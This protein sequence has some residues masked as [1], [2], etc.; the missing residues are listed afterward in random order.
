L[1][2]LLKGMK[3]DDAPDLLVGFD[4]ADD[5]GVFRLRDDLA[6]VQTVDVITPVCDDPFLFGQVAAANSLS[7]VYAMGG[8][9][10]TVMN[11]C[12]FPSKGV[13]PGIFERIL[14]GGHQKTVEAGAVLVGGHTVKDEEL[15]FGLSVTGTIH[16]DKILRNST[17]KAG[18][19]LVLTKPLGTGVM[20]SASNRG[21][22]PWERFERVVAN[23]ARLNAV[24]GELAAAY[25]AGAC[26]DVTGFGLAGHGLEM[27]R[28]A[29]VGLRLR[30]GRL[31]RY[32]EC[33]DLIAQGVRVGM[34]GSN[35]AMAGDAVEFDGGI[36]ESEQ[37]MLFDP[38]TSGGLLIAVEAA[39]AA[40][41]VREMNELGEADAVVVGE[42]FASP[43]PV[44]HVLP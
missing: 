28:G 40:D 20:I 11:I 4:T 26:T 25:E 37:W 2:G 44:I 24:A 17:A 39:K 42:V 14:E 16:P 41:L 35:R 30:F 29:G 5:A 9:P 13:P 34:A 18:Q 15:K 33:V 10:L 27:A 31:P 23:M 6:I 8:K 12:C 38:Q 3:R 43:T 19:A 1:G 21:I 22:V 32:A 7:D 36:T